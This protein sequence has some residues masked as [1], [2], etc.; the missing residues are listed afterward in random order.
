MTAYVHQINRRTQCLGHLIKHVI[1]NIE[2][3]LT[4][5]FSGMRLVLP[6]RFRS[7]HSFVLAKSEITLRRWCAATWLR[8]WLAHAN[9]LKVVC[10]SSVKFNW[11]LQC[12][13]AGC[14]P[15][16]VPIGIINEESSVR[17]RV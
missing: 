9:I 2:L 15:S 4:W 5:H 17:L 6:F 8:S 16:A 11:C 14:E 12:L 3:S 1:V 13:R 10:P 7:Q